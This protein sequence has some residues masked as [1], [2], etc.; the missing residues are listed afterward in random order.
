MEP[1]SSQIRVLAFIAKR[2]H[3]WSATAIGRIA[4][5]TVKLAKADAAIAQQLQTGGLL[6][7]DLYLTKEGLN[8][9]GALYKTRS[10]LLQFAALA[11]PRIQDG[12]IEF[13]EATKSSK[14]ASKAAP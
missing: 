13:Q 4:D 14:P 7:K 2:T 5:P 12:S 1:D 6:D 10:G 8:K 9:I 11:M 3:T